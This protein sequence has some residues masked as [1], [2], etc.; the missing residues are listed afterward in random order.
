MAK[1]DFKIRFQMTSYNNILLFTV[2]LLFFQCL[3]WIKYVD[4]GRLDHYMFKSMG[5][6]CL[7]SDG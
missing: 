4:A 7:I 6:L 1:A 5:H 2:L 3:E